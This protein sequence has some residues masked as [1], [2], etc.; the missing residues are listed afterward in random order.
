MFECPTT[1]RILEDVAT[2]YDIETA[3]EDSNVSV[4]RRLFH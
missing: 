3:E 4:R 2:S 1:A